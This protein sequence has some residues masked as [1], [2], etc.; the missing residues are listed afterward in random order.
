MH[1]IFNRIFPRNFLFT[2]LAIVS[3]IALYLLQPLQFGVVCYKLALV[4]MGATVGYWLDRSLFP[5]ARPDGFLKR[6]WQHG[7]EEPEGEADFEVV[8]GYGWVYAI[9]MIRRA[10]IIF[11]VVL[12]LTLGL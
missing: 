7:T 5:Y 1:E 3:L 9:C 6:C 10:L 11:A 4:F 8:E 12:G 2:I